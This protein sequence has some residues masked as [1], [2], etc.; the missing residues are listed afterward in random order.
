MTKRV[1][2]RKKLGG[3]VVAGLLG[4]GLFASLAST[5]EDGDSPTVVESGEASDGG[6]G[7]EDASQDSAA[8]STEVS[9][10]AIGTA[11]T[12]GD[13]GIARVN[14]VVPEAAP[15]NEF[16]GPDPGFT[17]TEVEVEMCAGSD[18]WSV[19]PL[20]WSGFLAD[21]T[22]ASTSFAGNELSTTTLA[23]GGCARG[24]VALEVP[25]GEE[26]ADVVLTSALFSEKARWST[27]SSQPVSGPLEPSSPPNAAALGEAMD[28][29]SQSTATVRTI[30]A[31]IPAPDFVSVRE[32][33]QLIEIDVEQCAGSESLPVNPLYWSLTTADNFVAQAELGGQSLPTIELSPEQCAAGTVIFTVPAD[34]T[35]R[36]VQIVGPLFDELGRTSVD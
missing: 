15:R 28:T 18:G 5:D 22:E 11:V 35:A 14:N 17:F 24:W 10:L 3:V 27:D 2:K 33:W 9:D 1:L 21:N 36:Y 31:G 23:P 25:D 29:G 6:T 30:T 26:V 12:F 8:A 7:S 32:G 20:Y 16:F 34:A 13:G 19:N 4:A